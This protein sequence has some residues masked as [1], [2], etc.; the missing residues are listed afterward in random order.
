MKIIKRD[1]AR[2]AKK[3]VCGN[4]VKLKIRCSRYLYTLRVA[5]HQ[6]AKKLWSSLP[7]GLK[8]EESD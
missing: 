4:I 1:D 6:K 7:P 8:K 5:D 2:L 3:K